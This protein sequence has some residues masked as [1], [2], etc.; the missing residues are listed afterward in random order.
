[1][2]RAVVKRRLGVFVLR[3]RAIQGGRW[4]G[5]LREAPEVPLVEGGPFNSTLASGIQVHL[6]P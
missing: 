2:E 5:V 1:M 6:E 4:P 3:E